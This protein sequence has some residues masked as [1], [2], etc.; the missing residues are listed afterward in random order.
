[1]KFKFALLNLT[2]V[3]RIPLLLA[4]ALGLI[5]WLGPCCGGNSSVFAATTP[6]FVQEKDNQV[7][8]GRTTSVSFSSF[9]TTGNIIVAYVIWDNTSTATVSDSNGNV[10]ASAAGPTRW[11]SNKY[12]AQVFYAKNTKSG[13]DT[14][15]ATFGTAVQSWGIIYAHE[16]SGLDLTTPIDVTAAASGNSGSMNSGSVT[17]TNPTDLLFGAGVS[18]N[19]VSAPGAGYIIRA[20]AHGNIT[21]D[22]NV[23]TT[24]SY[25]ATATHSNGTWAMQMVAFRAAATVADNVAP[26]VPAGLAA[27]VVSSSQINLS[28]TASTDNASTPAQISYFCYRNGVQFAATAAG[29]TS[30]SDTGLTASTTYTYTVAAKDAVGNTSSQS[31]GV[32]AT[33]QPPPVVINSFTASPASITAGQSSTLSWS[34]SNATLLTIDNGVGTVTGTT[35][36]S[37]SPAVTTVYHLTAS[38]SAGS[39][40][41]QTTV[42]VTSDTTP[43]SVPAGLVATVI[44]STQINLSWTASSDNIGAAGQISYLCYR[45]GVQFAATA[46][47]TTSCSDTGLTASTT[48]TYTVAAKDAAGNTSS[49]S[50]GVQAT[51]QPAPVVINS[52]SAG[53]ASITAG[54]SST[55]SWNVSNATS[56]TIDNGVGTVTGTTSVNVSPAVTTVYHLTAS[57]GAGS[58]SM[59]TTVTVTP[60]TTPPSVP[61]GL[62]ATVISS[63]QINL[64]WTASSDNISAPGQISYLCYRNGVQ[65][66]ATAAGTTSCSD[67]GLTASTTYTYTVAAKDAAGNTS[68]QS[69]GVPA[70][71]QPTPVVINSFTAGPASITAGQSSTLSWNVSNA[72]SLTIDNGVGTVTG[73]TS[74]NVNPAVTKGYHL[75]A[76]N[77][78]GST[79]A[80]AT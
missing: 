60:D 7:T 11:S 3:L 28:W 64:S 30:C 16:Y 61:A 13:A 72:T 37:V 46:A 77:S 12:S 73:T 10:Y 49:Q 14:V 58:T 68:S 2:K 17:T 57:N 42:T 4:V 36:K 29:T 20:T 44:S 26:S 5:A 59:Q 70:T 27:S 80:Q 9:T 71:T 34:V 76:S 33:T 39:T 54:Q 22:K 31:A 53:P 69:A 78:A 41:A 18:A 43:P 47:G 15:T 66:A 1:M 40:T 19:V 35:S 50:A 65:F 45:N 55:L 6:T 74:I 52:F 25:N 24:G 48:Y 8:A 63:T 62:V 32:Q 56:L 67:T 23:L 21:E 79:T 51:T 38:N 75:T